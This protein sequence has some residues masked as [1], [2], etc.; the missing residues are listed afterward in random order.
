MIATIATEFE[1]HR[2]IAKETNQRIIRMD[3]MDEGEGGR[4]QEQIEG[5]IA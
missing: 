3:D 2:S 4:K 1:W 5:S